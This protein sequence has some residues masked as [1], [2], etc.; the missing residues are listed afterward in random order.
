[1]WGRCSAGNWGDNSGGCWMARQL[2]WVPASSKDLTTAAWWATYWAE[3][4][5]ELWETKRVGKLD[6]LVCSWVCWRGVRS[7]V[8]TVVVMVAS[9]AETL[10]LTGHALVL[11]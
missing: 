5:A 4:M 11:K 2:V 3:M 10:V 6:L 8:V 9:S 7:A 1:M